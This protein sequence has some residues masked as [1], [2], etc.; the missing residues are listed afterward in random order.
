[1]GSF[2][3]S[4]AGSSPTRLSVNRRS[5]FSKPI[6]HPTLSGALPKY[7]V[8]EVPSSDTNA[9]GMNQSIIKYK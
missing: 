5:L 1:M 9:I 8:P 6:K 3:F 4:E 2:Y 7:G